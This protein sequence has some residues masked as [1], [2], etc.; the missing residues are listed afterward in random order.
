MP[1]VYFTAI[2]PAY[3]QEDPLNP[4]CSEDSAYPAAPDSEY[5]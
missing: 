2:Y 3:N 1:P 5:G 4:Q